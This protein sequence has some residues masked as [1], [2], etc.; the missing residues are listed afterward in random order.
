MKKGHAILMAAI[1]AALYLTGQIVVWRAQRFDYVYNYMFEF[2]TPKLRELLACGHDN[3]LADLTLI[4]GVQFYGRNY[5]LLD[6]HPVKYDQ[7]KS[8]GTSLASLDPRHLEGFHFWGFALTTAQRGKVDAYRFLIQGA[9][10]LCVTD[11]HFHAM[12]PDMWKLAKEAGYV[13][14]YELKNAT[15]EWSCQ[16]Y[17]LAERSPECPEFINR[18]KYYA[19]KELEPDPMPPLLE[20]AQHAA[21]TNNE[22]LRQLNIDHIRRIIAAEH[23]VYWDM[24]EAVYHEIHAASP[25]RIADLNTIQIMKEAANRYRE[26]SAKWF[27]DGKTRL[28]PNLLN[29]EIPPGQ[30]PVV[31]EAVEPEQPIDPYGGQYVI[32]QV[33]G[34]SALLGTGVILDERDDILKEYQ[35]ELDAYKEAHKGECPPDLDTFRK[36]RVIEKFVIADQLGYPV[37]FDP[38]TCT[39]TWPPIAEESPPPLS[40]YGKTKE[41]REEAAKA[42]E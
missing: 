28:Y 42:K 10:N 19:C 4:R 3:M 30:A 12:I 22:A 33:E 31:K 15:P 36:A 23:K 6:K 9:H 7:F 27:S 41:E 32:L 11:E 17:E 8:L 18:L 29:P 37:H 13:G 21:T 34:N 20:L 2:T 1:L 25:T 26:R 16:A 40:P 39:L 38:G 14:Y 5:P 35:V 24:A